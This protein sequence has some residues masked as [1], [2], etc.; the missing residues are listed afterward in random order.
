MTRKILLFCDIFLQFAYYFMLYP[1]YSRIL[2]QDLFVSYQDTFY[3][4]HYSRKKKWY[5]GP[6]LQDICLLSGSVF[7]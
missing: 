5:L 7:L 1:S 3:Y 4:S 6:D 2:T